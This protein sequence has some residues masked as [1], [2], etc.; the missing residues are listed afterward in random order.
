MGR[1]NRGDLTIRAVLMVVLCA[2]LAFIAGCSTRQESDQQIQRQAQQATQQAKVAAQKAAA[3]ARVAA[4]NAERDAHDIAKGVR[5]GLHNGKDGADLVNVNSASRAELETLPGVTPATA[6][7]IAAHR[8]YDGPHD[9]VSKGAVSETEY[10]RIAG[11]VVA[12]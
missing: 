7:R 3:E 9:L 5:A 1:K 6:H 11:D 8:P 10:A 4:A 12:H 2:A